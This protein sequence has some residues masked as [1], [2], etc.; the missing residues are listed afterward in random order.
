LAFSHSLDVLD[1][2]C[3]SDISCLFRSGFGLK[4]WTSPVNLVPRGAQVLPSLCQFVTHPGLVSLW[5]GVGRGRDAVTEWLMVQSEA[6]RLAA[7][8]GNL[9]RSICDHHGT[10][11]WLMITGP[12]KITLFRPLDFG[13]R[14]GGWS[15][16]LVPCCLQWKIASATAREE[17]TRKAAT[18]RPGHHGVDRA[19]LT[20]LRRTLIYLTNRACLCISTLTG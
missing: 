11:Q 4:H 5:F 9:A 13:W 18:G 14:M 1:S 12:N 16:E 10:T 15:I 7:A 2:H 20:F 6:S 3:S 19:N 17:R 8:M